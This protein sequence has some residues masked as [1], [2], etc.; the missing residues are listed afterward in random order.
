MNSKTDRLDALFQGWKE[1]Y[2]EQ[3][4]KKFCKDG[5]VKEEKWTNSEAKTLFLLKETN[6]YPGD[7]RKDII[8]RCPA[9]WPN[10]GRWAYGLRVARTGGNPTFAD[11]VKNYR[12]ALESSAVMNLKK[13]TGEGSSKTEELIEAIKR[14]KNFIK[15]ELEIIEPEIVVCGLPLMQSKE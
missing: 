2:G 5:I 3:D 15:E 14:D 10:V 12:D 11:A 8:E 4:R 1:S 9:P 7:V 13:L 6:K